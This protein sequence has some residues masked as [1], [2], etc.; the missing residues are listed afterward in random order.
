MAAKGE[1]GAPSLRHGLEAACGTGQK[2]ASQRVNLR[3][4]IRL[5]GARRWRSYH[6]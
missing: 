2:H 5:G 1:L 6:A 4:L 3:A